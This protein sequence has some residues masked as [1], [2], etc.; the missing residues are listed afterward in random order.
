MLVGRVNSIAMHGCIAEIDKTA[1]HIVNSF[2]SFR[3]IL[4]DMLK[5]LICDV[6][7]AESSAEYLQQAK[8][9][10]FKTRK[11]RWIGLNWTQGTY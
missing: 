4:D 7:Y 9:D 6:K 2:F 10:G 8:T 5:C 1:W 11:N 3:A